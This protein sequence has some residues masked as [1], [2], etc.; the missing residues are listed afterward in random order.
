M[1]YA[2]MMLAV[3]SVCSPFEPINET[4]ISRGLNERT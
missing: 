3:A 4:D 1:S 2:H